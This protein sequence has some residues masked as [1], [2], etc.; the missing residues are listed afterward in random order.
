MVWYI[1]LRFLE[2]SFLFIKAIFPLF[3]LYLG[4]LPFD[5]FLLASWERLHNCSSSLLAETILGTFIQGAGWDVN[6]SL[7]VGVVQK[8]S[9]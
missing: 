4:L 5:K 1:F 9:Y 3:F 6:L 8:Y 2:V 7:L